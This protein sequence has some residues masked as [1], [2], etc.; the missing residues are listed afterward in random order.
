MAN[1]LIRNDPVAHYVASFSPKIDVIMI[2]QI[3]IQ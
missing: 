1:S 3:E 2:L